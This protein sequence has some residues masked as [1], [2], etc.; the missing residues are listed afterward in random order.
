EQGHQVSPGTHRWLHLRGRPLRVRDE[1]VLLPERLRGTRTGDLDTGYLHLR[2]PGAGPDPGLQGRL[3]RCP[4]DTL[5][6]GRGHRSDVGTLPPL[7]RPGRCRRP[8]RLRGEVHEALALLLELGHVR[9]RLRRWRRRPRPGSAA[10]GP[11]QSQQYPPG[12]V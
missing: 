10:H 1:R 9:R 2:L 7:P 6:V 3:E 12:R 5:H 11:R 8:G 4:G